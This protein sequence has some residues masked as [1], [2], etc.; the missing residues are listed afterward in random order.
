MTVL[1]REGSLSYFAHREGSALR[2]AFRY[3]WRIW[4]LPELRDLLNEAGFSRGE[5]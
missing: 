3:D 2:D 1:R 4:S 5:V